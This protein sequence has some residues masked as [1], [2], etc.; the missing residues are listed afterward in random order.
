MY[1]RSLCLGLGVLGW[2]LVVQGCAGAPVQQ[3][4]PA[5]PPPQA[6]APAPTPPPAPALD[7][8]VKR[9]LVRDLLAAVDTYYRLLQDKSVEQAAEFVPEPQRRA[10]LDGLWDLVAQ[11]R[12]E[13]A[14]VQS[15][16]LFPQADSVVMAKVRVVLTLFRRDAVVPERTELWM[17]WH[18]RDDRWELV[19]QE[20]K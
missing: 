2:V 12:I 8:R 19:P 5:A 4:P 14:D 11:Y 13:S 17:T 10:H 6:A 18:H 9:R 3:A 15:Y 20:K 1:T 16:Q 7:P